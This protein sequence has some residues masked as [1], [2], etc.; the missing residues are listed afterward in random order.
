[1]STIQP[2]YKNSGFTLVEILVVLSIVVLIGLVVTK[3]FSDIFSVN[4]NVSDSFTQTGEARRAIKTMT[5]ELR[6]ASQSSLGAYALEQTGTSSLVFFSDIDSDSDKE[7]IRYF[8]QSGTLMRGVTNP[9]GTTLVYNIANEVRTELVHA[10][11]NS[12]TTPLFSY[13][14]ETYAGTTTPLVAPINISVVRLVKIYI[15]V[16]NSSTT[17]ST[18]DIYTTQINLRNLKDNL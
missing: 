5:A 15:L 4:R 14:N 11:K 9:T 13:Y 10:M 12:S 6:T 18:P 1:M 17:S 2:S 3:L 16:N 7:R 8:I